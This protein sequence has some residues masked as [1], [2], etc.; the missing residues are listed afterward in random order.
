MVLV[1]DSET[2]TYGMEIEVLGYRMMVVLG[3]RG[4]VLLGVTRRGMGMIGVRMMR[5][6][7]LGMDVSDVPVR[8]DLEEVCDGQDQDDT[9]P[10]GAQ[11]FG[12]VRFHNLG[13][14][15]PGSRSVNLGG[16][17]PGT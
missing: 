7:R 5:R 1:D 16:S 13:K 3:P 4:V 10:K 6:M 17:G 2:E 11:E 15:T 12:I 8:R 9:R 14:L